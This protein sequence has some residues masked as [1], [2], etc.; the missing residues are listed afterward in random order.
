MIIMAKMIDFCKDAH[1]HYRF[2]VAGGGDFAE[3]I[4]RLKTIPL[5]QRAWHEDTKKWEI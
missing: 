1:G 2:N 4:A 5:H 3:A